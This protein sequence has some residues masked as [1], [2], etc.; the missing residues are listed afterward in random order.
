VP[1]DATADACR[2][3]IWFEPMSLGSIWGHPR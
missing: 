2:L 1:R 3:L